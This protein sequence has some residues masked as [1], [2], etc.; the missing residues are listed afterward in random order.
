MH[1]LPRSAQLYIVAVTLLGIGAAAAASLIHFRTSEAPFWELLVFVAIAVLAGGKKVSVIRNLP[2]EEAGSMSLGFAITFAGLLRFDPSAAVLIGVASCFSSCLFPHRQA[3]HQILFNVSL[4]ALEALAGGSVFFLLSSGYQSVESAVPQ[5][6]LAVA[7]SSLTFFFVNTFGVGVI[8]GLCSRKSPVQI[9]RDTFLWTAPSYFAAASISALTVTIF[10]GHTGAV[11]LFVAPV[12]YLMYSSYAAYAARAEEKQRHIEA[13]QV[14][15]A[16]LADLYLATIK[17]L[18]LAIDA[19]DQHTHQ[20]ILRVQ[21]YAVGIATEMGFSGPELDAITTGALLHDIGKLGVPEYV[22]LK[23]RPGAL[24]VAGHPDRPAPPR[25]VGRHR[26]PRRA[27]G[28][29]HPPYGADHGRRRRVR[30]PHLLSLLPQG[31]DLREGEGV[32]RGAVGQPLRP[33]GRRAFPPRDRPGSGRDA[34][35]W[36]LCGAVLRRLGGAGG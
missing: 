31:V 35:Q 21:K 30:R 20:H 16:Q 27:Q 4:A 29:G 33:A 12:A 1:K 6:F 9:W 24:P 25:E 2:E 5:T 3:M 19:K 32:R 11:F 10:K 13:L 8:I 34:S 17:S 14:S 22:L 18:A 36:A 15:Q 23:P 28:G 7:G 26:L